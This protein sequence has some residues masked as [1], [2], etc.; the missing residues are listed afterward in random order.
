MG[1]FAAIWNGFR[2]LLGLVLPFFSKT[3]D[4][5]GMG[6]QL[7]RVLHVVM[8]VAILV[9]LAIIHRLLDWGVLIKAP[10]ALLRDYW[11][12]L[13]FLLLY[14]LMWL[15]CWLWKLLQPE[16]EASIFP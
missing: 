7:R 4:L 16:E 10:Y 5:K 2:Q 11:S 12:P 1:L 14:V 8:L 9:G 3:C 13:L 15:G 6:P